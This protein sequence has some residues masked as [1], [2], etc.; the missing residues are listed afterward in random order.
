MVSYTPPHCERVLHSA[1]PILNYEHAA[2]YARNVIELRAKDRITGMGPWLSNH[3]LTTLYLAGGSLLPGRPSDLDFF[4]VPTPDGREPF[5]K[6]VDPTDK[7][8]QIETFPFANRSGVTAQFVDYAPPTTL[9]NPDGSSVW[10]VW[11]GLRDLVEDF[12]FAHCKVGVRLLETGPGLWI[13]AD[14]YLSPDF[15]A[16]QT[17]G[18][19][20]YT[21]GR[22]PLGSLARIGKIAL[23]LR[24]TEQEA[25][26]LAS[27]VVD[28]IKVIGVEKASTWPVWSEKR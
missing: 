19:T 27:Q 8:T 2:A 26:A 22:G 4:P 20:F 17:A 16:A 24:L 10:N 21:K 14:T 7:G 28:H 25:H 9:T 6:L 3:G 12:D 15:I 5:T 18:G 13:V 1:A 11:R 23:K